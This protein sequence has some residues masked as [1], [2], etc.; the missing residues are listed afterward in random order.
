LGVMAAGFNDKLVVGCRCESGP[1]S[2]QEAGK[3]AGGSV[4]KRG[5]VEAQRQ[6]PHGGDD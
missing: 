4:W 2:C 6:Q 3:R 5:R 1:G